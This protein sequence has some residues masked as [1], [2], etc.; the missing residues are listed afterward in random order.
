M[1]LSNIAL[2]DEG[3]PPPCP[4]QFNIAEYVLAAGA[5]E[6]IALRVL[7]GPGDE[8]ERWSYADLRQAILAVARG[9]NVTP[10]ER[11]LIHLGNSSAFPI[12]FF[13]A[14]AAGAIAVPT[15]FQL[16]TPELQKII[17]AV[18]PTVIIAP[19]ER[20][21]GALSETQLLDMADGT[22]GDFMPTRA[23]DPAYIVFTSGS[24][25]QPKGVLHAHRA[26]WARR[27]MWADW[28]GLGRDDLMLHAG[29]FNWT[30]TLG[31]GLTD[32]WAAGASTLIY[33]GPQDDPEV[34]PA[35]MAAH[36]P[37]IFAAVPGLYRKILRTTGNLRSGGLR[38]G[39]TAGEA[40]PERVRT[41]WTAR[42][43]TPL[44]EALGMSE[45]STYISGRPETP[46]KPGSVGQPQSG[47]R[48]AVLED[49]GAGFGQTNTPGRLAVHRDD[50]GLMQGY[51]ND[52]AATVASFEGDWFVT[53][54]RAAMDAEGWITYHGRS[55]DV[56]TAQG[57]RVAPQEV[58]AVLQAHPDVRE[59]AVAEVAHGEVRVI[60]AFVI[61]ECAGLK[62]HCHAHLAP[63][64]TPKAFI[65]VEALP[66]NAN[67]KL[68]RRALADLV[69]A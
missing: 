10:G 50:P 23:E 7:N 1:Q 8:L 14:L 12:S 44:L 69:P 41:D 59:A 65:S 30:Y 49:E 26:A 60:T 28:Y 64:K 66:R 53:G 6:K 9:L 54:D 15:S 38:H 56:M 43:S 31:A 68:N 52:E 48:I 24:S 42:T 32:P 5:P 61:G 21:P 35:L 11:V 62:D 13:G 57:Y 34:W 67:G 36:H 39:L 40:L 25:G 16:T 37:T 47:R 55:D 20:V 63:Y 19:P 27:M 4:A 17:A 3:P 29:A 46:H 22:P 18:S 2:F 51:W 45:V 33:T 58:E